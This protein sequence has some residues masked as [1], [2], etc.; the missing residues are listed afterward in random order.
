MRVGIWWCLFQRR[1]WQST[2]AFLPEESH[3]LFPFQFSRSVVSDSLR[4]H[5]LQHARPPCPSP[6]PGVYSNSNSIELVMTSN[7]LILCR[8][9]LLPPSIFPSIRVLSNKS[10]LHI[11]WTKYW[12]FS[13][14][15][16]PCNEHS[17]PQTCG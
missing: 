3:G 15:I 6:T 12:S 8:P 1:K 4:P 10:V 14:N 5:G 16:S 11:R 7:H 13:F 17:G 9:L 2:P